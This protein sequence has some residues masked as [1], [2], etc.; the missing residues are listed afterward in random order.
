MADRFVAIDRS[1]DA[2]NIFNCLTGELEDTMSLPARTGYSILDM[3]YDGQ[4]VAVLALSLGKLWFVNIAGAGGT[5][6]FDIE[7]TVP[8]GHGFDALGNYYL[9]RPASGGS[10]FKFP[11]PYVSAELVTASEPISFVPSPTPE[12]A[13]ALHATSSGVASYARFNLTSGA[14]GGD[15]GPVPVDYAIGKA[16]ISPGSDRA[17]VIYPDQYGVRAYNYDTGAPTGGTTPISGEG[18]SQGWNNGFGFSPDGAYFVVKLTDNSLGYGAVSGGVPTSISLDP[19]FQYTG[20]NAF[21]Y[22]EGMLTSEL[23]LLT[24]GIFMIAFNVLD[25]S[26]AWV[27]PY[28]ADRRNPENKSSACLQPVGSGDT[29]EPPDPTGFWKDIVLAYESA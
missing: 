18:G 7:D 23:A 9:G 10:Y 24:Y 26:V 15:F 4:W 13:M 17:F 1:D 8:N 2:F 19:V 3:S 25:G 21:I 20:N 16:I 28:G 14:L 12:R 27:T 6:T 29:P 22:V 11:A 5:H